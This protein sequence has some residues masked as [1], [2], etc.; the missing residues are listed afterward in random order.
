[1]PD[2]RNRAGTGI[3]KTDLLVVNGQI[4]VLDSGNVL[5]PVLPVYSVIV[6]AV[7]LAQIN[8]GFTVLPGIPGKTFKVLKYLEVMNG[9]FL[10]ATDIRLQDTSAVVINTLLIAGATTGAKIASEVVNANVTDGAGAF[11]NLTLGAGIQLVKTGAAA[12]GGTSI[13]VEIFFNII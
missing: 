10:T 1:M 11:A 13:M 9:T 8:A 7:T 2:Y 4:S 5:V 6:P 12:T 3:V